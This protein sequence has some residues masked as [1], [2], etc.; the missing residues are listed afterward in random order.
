MRKAAATTLKW[1]WIVAVLAV[2][3]HIAWRSRADLVIALR[4]LSLPMLVMSVMSMVSAKLLLG[5]N[6]RLAAGRASLVLSYGTALRL[7]NLSQLGKYLPGSVWQFVGRAAAYRELGADYRQIRDSLL[8]ETVWIICGAATLAI[9]LCGPA[10]VVLVHDSLSP[11]VRWWLAIA[12]ATGAI[13]VLSL[14]VLKR[15]VLAH[16]MRLAL[17]G[18]HVLCVQAGTWLLLGISFWLLARACGIQAELLFSIGLFAGAYAVG[19][20]VPFA[21]AG[22]GVRDGILVVGLLQY[23]QPGEVLAVAVLARLVYLLVE[24]CL[25]VAQEGGIAFGRRVH[26][27]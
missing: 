12:L 19:F 26:R 17:P 7:Y 1:A 20:I 25:V 24:L 23:A 8:I 9:L 27:D 15:S 21:P 10:V 18:P 5:E 6:A 4:D 14:L 13:A 22:L 3:L 11:L 16:V 2:C